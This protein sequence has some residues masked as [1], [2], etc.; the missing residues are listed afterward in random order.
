MAVSD[1]R[2]SSLRPGAS[3]ENMTAAL[4]PTARGVRRDTERCYRAVTSRDD[5]FDGQFIVAVRTAGTILPAVLP[6]PDSEA[7]ERELLPHLRGGTGRSL[8]KSRRCLPD[9]VPGSPERNVRADLAA[10]AMRAD[11]RRRS[12]TPGGI[13]KSFG[14]NCWHYPVSTHGPR[15]TS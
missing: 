6:R 4:E 5:R 1:F 13:L 10:R 15:T 2:Q 9:A 7:E 12:R 11:L 8:P 3:I 14:P